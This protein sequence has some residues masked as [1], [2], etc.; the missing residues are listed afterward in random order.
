[1]K[2]TFVFLLL[3]LA[4]CGFFKDY[5]KNDQWSYFEEWDTTKDAKIDKQEFMAGCVKEDFVKTDEQAKADE[6]FMKADE[7]QDGFL[8]GLEFYRWKIRASSEDDSISS[9]R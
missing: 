8:T 9:R 3:A 4:G 1:M 2:F 5:S 6:L 7:N